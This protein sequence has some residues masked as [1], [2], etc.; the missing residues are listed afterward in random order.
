MALTL[1]QIEQWLAE[2]SELRHLEF[3]AAKTQF[4]RTKLY[5]YCVAIAN[6]GGGHLVFGVADRP[7]RVTGTAAFE[8]HARVEH[9]V[10]QKT[11]IRIAV[12]AVDHPDGR[13][14]A[15]SIPSRPPGA[16]HHLDGRYLM[17]AGE[18]TV[19]MHNERLREIHA[20]GQPGWLDQHA[21]TGLSAEA[22]LEL[23]DARVFFELG[24]MPRPATDAEAIGQLVAMQCL[25][26]NGNGH[27]IRRV[28]ALLF[29]RR[30][31]DFPALRDKAVRVLVYPGESRLET[32][33]DWS[34]DQGYAVGFRKIVEYIMEQIPQREVIQGA[35]RREIRLLPE[36]IARELV[37]NAMAHQDF[38]VG[39][40]EV[41]VEIYSNRAE[42][43]NPGEP[44]VPVADFI[45]IDRARN[46]HLIE[47]M[48]R[49]NL[50]E[51]RGSG[52]DQVIRAAET[53]HLRAPEFRQDQLHT[54]VLIRSKKPLTELSPAE[55]VRACHQHCELKYVLQEEA[56]SNR[57]LRE[58]FGAPAN[59]APLVSR[60]IAETVRQG[61]VKPDPRTGRSR[62]FASY[63][64]A[65]A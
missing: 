15:C 3:K 40:K 31:S 63:L 53:H 48:R 20:E 34:C 2:P 10:L 58:R 17:R 1:A 64:P 44:L 38:A 7:R 46:G 27:A 16:A 41:R 56:M 61:F 47:L 19:P 8:D 23:L 33:R 6:E 4:S 13:V 55:R 11:G 59:S 9:D 42:F 22:V 60:I 62:R 14:V 35:L 57:S 54:S 5:E 52:I 49:M 12:E 30:L 21:R 65:W 43:S 51:R 26:A 36:E 50:C 25:D 18:S 24:G 45:R 28:G 29:A 32:R 39:G 37:A